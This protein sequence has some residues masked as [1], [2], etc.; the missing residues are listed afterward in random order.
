M[1]RRA[2]VYLGLRYTT[3]GSQAPTG[4]VWMKSDEVW[5]STCPHFLSRPLNRNVSFSRRFIIHRPWWRFVTI[6]DPSEIFRLKTTTDPNSDAGEPIRTAHSYRQLPIIPTWKRRPSWCCGLGFYLHLSLMN[7]SNITIRVSANFSMHFHRSLTPS[8]L[9]IS[10]ADQ[11]YHMKITTRRIKFC[12]A[13]FHPSHPRSSIRIWK[14]SVHDLIELG[15]E[16]HQIWLSIH[17]SRLSMEIPH[18]DWHRPMHTPMIM[19]EFHH[20]M[21]YQ[22]L[23][24]ATKD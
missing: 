17:L 3:T 15:V 14:L 21:K 5:A 4:K 2:R 16:V 24:A 20:S 11:Y 9:I 8:A 23:C 7:A 1:T 12:L 6:C 22:F 18:V 13:I 19:F 10:M